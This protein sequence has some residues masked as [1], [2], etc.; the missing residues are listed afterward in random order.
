MSALV[1]QPPPEHRAGLRRLFGALPVWGW[2]VITAIAGGIAGLGG[3]T[4]FYAE[5]A[6]YLSDDPRACVNCHVMRDVYAAWGKSSHK[7]V[8]VCNDCHTPHNSILSKY[9]VKALNGFNHSIAF[10]TDT[11]PRPIRITSLNRDVAQHNCLY[12]HAEVTAQISHAESTEPTD[13]LR[14]HSRVGHDY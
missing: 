7:T 5:G 6:S 13:C 14:C 8:A 1:G 11:Y 10:T 9:A 4:F 12:C 2:M 3:Y